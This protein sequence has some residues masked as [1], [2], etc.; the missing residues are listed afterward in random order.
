M[1]NS[2]T[3][4]KLMLLALCFKFITSQEESISPY[5]GMSEMNRCRVYKVIKNITAVDIMLFCVCQ[6]Y[7]C[8][9]VDYKILGSEY[10]DR[11][12]SWQC[13]QI[14][15]FKKWSKFLTN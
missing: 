7:K 8:V 1:T 14:R 9:P 3:K 12:F 15:Y 13:F 4:M 11:N 6:R 5:K 10:C 2:I